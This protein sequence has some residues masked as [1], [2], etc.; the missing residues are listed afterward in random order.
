LPIKAVLAIARELCEVL[1]VAHRIGIVHRDLKPENL[2]LTNEGELKV[3]D[4][5]L[6]HLRDAARPKETHTGMVFGTPAFMPPEQASGQTSQ[7]DART[8]IWA[9]GA[10]M[11][12]LLSGELVHRGETAQHFVM[13]SAME[14]ARS[15]RAAMPHAHPMLVQL[16]D[17]ALAREKDRRWQSADAMREAIVGVSESL[18]GDPEIPMM[19]PAAIAERSSAR[20]VPRTREAGAHQGGEEKRKRAAALPTIER[21]IDDSSSDQTQV[22]APEALVLDSSDEATEPGGRP[23][24][25]GSSDTPTE[26]TTPDGLPTQV[27][28]RIDSRPEPATA[29]PASWSDLRKAVESKRRD[30]TIPLRDART[31]DAAPADDET[32]LLKTQFRPSLEKV[33][34]AATPKAPRAVAVTPTPPREHR[35]ALI[36]HTR[37]PKP[38]TLPARSSLPPYLPVVVA[39]AFLGLRPLAYFLPRRSGAAPTADT[40]T[41]STMVL[42]SASAIA[43]PRTTAS[44]VAPVASAEP[45]QPRPS[46]P[47]TPPPLPSRPNESSTVIVP[48]NAPKTSARALPPNPYAPDDADLAPPPRSTTVSPATAPKAPASGFTQVDRRSNCT[49]PYVVDANG[50]LHWKEECLSNAKASPREEKATSERQ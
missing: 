2:F 33:R 34:Q 17:R 44:A 23:P 1:A 39:A 35:P 5:G 48:D 43:A 15:L 49:P 8:D 28:P 37:S 24:S 10:T 16:V 13:L 11:F 30:H 3:L 31:A 45:V 20:A 38:P 41:S 14:P 47:P 40:T 7:I 26:Q 21:I 18:V 9:V 36:A 29:R 50:K 19:S 12:T 22:R 4:F 6:A 32:A 27:R 25:G 46:A 42:P